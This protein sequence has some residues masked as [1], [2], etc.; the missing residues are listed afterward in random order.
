MWTCGRSLQAV[1]LCGLLITIHSASAATSDQLGLTSGSVSIDPSEL[2][3]DYTS[4]GTLNFA[5]EDPDS[6]DDTAVLAQL[7]PNQGRRR[8]MEEAPAIDIQSNRT[9]EFV[10]PIPAIGIGWTLL[11]GA[12]MYRIGCKVLRVKQ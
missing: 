12:G 3:F 9:G 5:V 1:L 11:I 10:V 7:S 6:A 8:I 4:S 2:V